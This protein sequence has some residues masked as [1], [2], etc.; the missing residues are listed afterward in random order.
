MVSVLGRTKESVADKYQG[1]RFKM[2]RVI[3]RQIKKMFY[4]LLMMM[5]LSAHPCASR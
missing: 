5:G 1:E 3:P 4:L 2:I